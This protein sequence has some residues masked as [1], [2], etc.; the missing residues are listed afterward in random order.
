MT[1][2]SAADRVFEVG[3]RRGFFWQSYEIYGGLS[4]MYDLGPYGAAMKEN[5][6]NEW[7]YYFIRRHQEIMAEI[8]TPI[9]GPEIV[10]AASGHLESFTDPIVTCQNCGRK[11]RADQLIEEVTGDKVEGKSND[12]LS[13]II[14]E[15]N[16]RCPICGGELGEVKSFN[17]LFKTQIGPYE[18]SNGYVRPELA[19]GMFLN[20]K[21]VY[22][23]MREKLPLGLA[24]VGRV[25]R[26]EISPRQGMLRLR[27]FT[28]M[29]FEF[30]FDPQEP[31][32]EKYLERVR[33]KTLRLISAED[34]LS[35][36]SEPRKMMLSEALETG[37]I[38]TPWLGYWM[39]VSQEFIRSLGVPEENIYFEEKLPEE[40]AH[41]SRQTFDQLVKTERWGWV[42]VAGHA[43]RGDYD[44]SRHSMYSKQD[45]S[46]FR[47]FEKPF[48]MKKKVVKVNRSILGK[49]FRE[50]AGEIE[51]ALTSMNPEVLKDLVN[52][53]REIEVSGFKVPTEA[54]VIEEVEERESGRKVIPHVVEPSFG[55]ERLL[56]VVMEY[57]L[58]EKEDRLILSIPPRLSPFKI[59]IFPLVNDERL[60]GMA[61]RIFEEL[62]QSG[63]PALYD[64]SGSIGRRY[65]RADEVGVP[66]AVTVDFRSIED[67]TVTV[68]YRDS[69][70]QERI[71]ASEVA[72]FLWKKLAH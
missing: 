25:G 64:D 48:I 38:K 35:G 23:V 53:R 56:Y 7:K 60:E 5:I 8:E 31:G 28:I 44:L 63:I 14:R 41:Y 21:R 55:V 43:Y 52:E 26:N 68:R 40:R 46:V 37:I 22:G 11:F 18:G 42:E 34:R 29:E 71:G 6:I 32:H 19:Q 10:Y 36:R 50:K 69:W 57:G 17:L 12:E 3:K 9:I 20:F 59:A 47:Q 62:K 67:G 33:D 27:E 51:G 66:F 72:E 61:K 15:K 16:I 2:S 24:Q 4:G 70:E 13:R 39:V 58:K 65:A 49:L 30:F 45:L 54:V 1:Q